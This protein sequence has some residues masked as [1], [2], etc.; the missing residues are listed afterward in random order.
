MAGLAPSAPL[1]CSRVDVSDLVV[2]LGERTPLPA[3]RD[4]ARLRLADAAFAALVGSTTEAGQASRHLVADLFGVDSLIG[5]THRYAAAVRMTEIDD[6]D[7]A[8]CVTPGS[9]VVPVVLGLA[10]RGL[11]ETGVDEVLDVIT[12]GYEVALGLG[13]AING[14]YLLARGTWPS[15]AIAGVVAAAVVSWL[16]N[17]GENRV[18][19]AV[20]LA[21]E[22][23]F[24][25]N[26]RGNS[27]EH[28]FAGAAATGVAAAF[29]AGRG[30]AVASGHGLL[31][32][33]VV[34]RPGPAARARVHRPAVKP[35]C[36]ARQVMTAVS[37]LCALISADSHGPAVD[38]DSIEHID[39]EVPAEYAV[40]L[41]KPVV[42]SRRESLS[43]AAYQLSL[44]VLDPAGLHDVARTN[45]HT[46]SGFG[47]LMARIAV[48]EADDLSQRYPL[49][50]P[51]RVRLAMR[52]G[53]TREA[54]EDSVPGEDELSADGL[55]AKIAAFASAVPGLPGGATELVDRALAATD[56]NDLA[57]IVAAVDAARSH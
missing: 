51:A 55:R 29:A 13:E 8:S 32:E 57:G 17:A 14:P 9:L 37:G 22:Q 6:I 23:G 43:S 34:S 7:L 15:L 12:R 3:D 38:A 21:V 33:L 42:T 39:V 30:F 50:W 24:G 11:L 56:L 31:D 25:G 5:R 54:D 27:R 46:D 49:R 35:F 26:A 48:R 53:E 44:A 52:G 41:D 36:S 20:T 10:G 18:R 45:L 16:T 47:A 4:A 1:T 28:L 2:R 40:M 19:Q